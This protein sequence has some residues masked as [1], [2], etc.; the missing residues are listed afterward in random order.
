MR[1]VAAAK[2]TI[3]QRF[4]RE[5]SGREQHNVLFAG[6]Y[7]HNLGNTDI[8]RHASG[9]YRFCRQEGLL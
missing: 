6:V 1:N 5:F 4:S 8:I 3:I 2:E 7:E 9:E